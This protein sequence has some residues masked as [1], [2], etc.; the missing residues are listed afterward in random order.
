MIGEVESYYH[1]VQPYLDLELANRGDGELWTWVAR[2]AG[3]RP[4]AGRVLEVGA[5]TGRATA[6]LARGAGEVVAFD[7]A[8]EL[9]AIARR[10]LAGTA[11]VRVLAAD[12]RHFQLAARFDLAVAVDDP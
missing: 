5:G 9:A 12:V 6:F 2:Q 1:R 3:P 10:R 4:G 7:L 11:G 8:L